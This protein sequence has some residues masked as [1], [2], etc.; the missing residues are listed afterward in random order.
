MYQI[1]LL[2][3][4]TILLSGVALAFD[5]LQQALPRFS[6]FNDEA[7]SSPTFRLVLGVTTI[8][9]GFFQFLTVAPGDIPVVGDLI[10]ALT[11]IVLGG[12]LAFDFYREKST[13][14]SPLVEKLDSLLVKNGSNF[15]VIGIVIAV[16]HFLF[17]RVLFL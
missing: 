17:H 10:P 9:V 7:L 15:G 1:Y 8:L 14:E 4:L 12:I 16:L 11:G 5:R 6:L 13:V 2:S 3:V